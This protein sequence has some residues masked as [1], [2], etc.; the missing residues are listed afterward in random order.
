[1]SVDESA[2]LE[3]L[4]AKEVPGTKHRI[5]AARRV[6]IETMVHSQKLP[7]LPCSRI[8]NIAPLVKARSRMTT[9]ASWTAIF[10]RAF[11]FTAERHA[12]LRRSIVPWPW[13][14]I[15]EHPRS[16]AVVP[17]EREIDGETVVLMAKVMRPELMTLAEIDQQLHTFSTQP[18]ESINYFRQ[19][20]LLGRLPWIFLRFAFWQTLYLSGFKKA[21]RFGTFAISSVGSLGSEIDHAWTPL[22]TYFTFGPIS[23][24]GDCTLR[25][26]FD[27]RV[28]DARTVARCLVSIE[29]ILHSQMLAEMQ[30]SFTA[31]VA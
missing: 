7:L 5:S 4:Q 12:E 14:S 8:V 30:P 13:Q 26:I 20:L 2:R 31:A 10:M 3:A 27:H 22:T 17:I 11:A 28:M 15:Y 25:I 16:N 19:L 23:P 29:E 6:V 9:P 1:M 21:K 18:V 24:A